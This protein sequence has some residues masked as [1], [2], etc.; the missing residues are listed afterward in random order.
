MTVVGS[1]F[2][3]CIADGA[4][5][6]I[7]MV[8]A[9]TAEA[10]DSLLQRSR[11]S[12]G[13]GRSNL[14][15]PASCGC[16]SPASRWAATPGSPA[17]PSGWSRAATAAPDGKAATAGGRAVMV[18]GRVRPAQ[19]GGQQKQVLRR[20]SISL[21][22]LIA[23]DTDFAGGL[24]SPGTPMAASLS[25]P[26]KLA[27]YPRSP[28]VSPEEYMIWRAAVQQ[29]WRHLRRAPR[30]LRQE[31]RLVLEAVKQDPRAFALATDK[32]R[33][34]PLLAREV[35]R[36]GGGLAL[37]GA[38]EAVKLDRNFVMDAV[39]SDGRALRDAFWTRHTE[40][41]ELVLEAVRCDWRALAHA[42][43]ELKADGA[44]ALEA[45]RQNW[46]ALEF[47]PESVCADREIMLEAVR[48][49]P[50]ALRWA[51]DTL[52]EDRGLQRAAREAGWSVLGNHE[53]S[54]PRCACEHW[55]M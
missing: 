11:S 40:D 2:S 44:I 34:D 14:A 21:A 51:A 1:Q 13:C 15:S 49:D 19:L 9:P 32:A 37:A 38:S 50:A 45:V 28:S 36:V 30:A 4:A 46:R 55:V 7:A 27:S 52:R 23:P 12:P 47:V 24:S 39:R 43:D 25:G 6:V 17:T 31:P 8:S 10:R 53:A 48:Q 35:L 41:R 33:N 29:D 42:S 54:T 3:V 22:I 16:T 18:G 26:E 20:R 5:G